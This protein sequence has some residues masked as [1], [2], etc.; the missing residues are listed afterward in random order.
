[1]DRTWEFFNALID[2]HGYSSYLEIGCKG[3]TTFNQV[4]A[5]RKVGVDPNSGGTLRMTSDE[6]FKSHTERFDLVFVD[7]M[8]ERAQVLRDVE[9]ALARLNDGGTIVLHD[10][11]PPSKERQSM[12]YV[13]Q[14]GHCGDVWKAFVDVRC[15]EGLDAACTTFDMGMGVIRVRANTDRVT[16]TRPPKELTWEDLEANRDRWLR[17]MPAADLLLW[18]R[19]PPVTA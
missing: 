6:Y 13:A 17:R 14:R 12:P 19:H 8:H 11:D 1:M 2:Q 7:G 16:T 18:V 3:D 10:C 15:R 5:A 9:N 4:R